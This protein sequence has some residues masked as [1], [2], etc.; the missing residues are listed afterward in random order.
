MIDVRRSLTL[1]DNGK[2]IL[3]SQKKCLKCGEYPLDIEKSR[4]KSGESLIFTINR[5]AI[6]YLIFIGL[7]L[8]CKCFIFISLPKGAIFIS[9]N[10]HY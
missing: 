9:Y 7:H 5:F 10:N 2:R 3:I 6:N 8:L 1:A 4:E